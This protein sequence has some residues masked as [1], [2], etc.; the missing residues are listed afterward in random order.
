M[1]LKDDIYGEMEVYLE[2]YNYCEFLY[3]KGLI[4]LSLKNEL[5]DRI[6]QKEKKKHIFVTKPFKTCD[7]IG[8]T[9]YDFMKVLRERGI[10]AEINARKVQ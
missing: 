6:K 7:A 2:A 3:E 8:E 4:D 10:I 1:N 9:L 5:K